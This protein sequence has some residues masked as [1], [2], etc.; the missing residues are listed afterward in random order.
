MFDFLNPIFNF[1]RNPSEYH[2][3]VG[4]VMLFNG[5]KYRLSRIIQHEKYFKPLIYH[6]IAIVTV[7]ER[8]SFT[9]EI[10]PI[11]LPEKKMLGHYLSDKTVF[12]SGFGDLSFG[13]APAPVLQ[14]VDLKIINNTVCE[15]NYRNL[16]ESKTKFPVGIGDS[17][18]C[19]GQEEGGKD[20][21]QVST[22]QDSV[23]R[24]EKL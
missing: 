8:I 23:Q 4:S 5:T 15:E 13:G 7:K 24:L 11:C 10:L 14:E 17:L 2:V 12:V 18:V 20:A 9:D 1:N 19:A 6:D 3:R 22:R 21:C 16:I